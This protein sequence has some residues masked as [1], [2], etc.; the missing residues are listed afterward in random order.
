MCFINHH[1]TETNGEV[2][3]YLHA[4]LTLALDGDPCNGYE[5]ESRLLLEYQGRRRGSVTNA[6]KAALRWALCSQ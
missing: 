6:L 3:E 5:C 2:E 4:F 1:I